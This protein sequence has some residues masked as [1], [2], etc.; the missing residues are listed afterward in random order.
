MAKRRRDSRISAAALYVK[1]V[2]STHA[3]HVLNC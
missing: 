1:H 3:L 2:L